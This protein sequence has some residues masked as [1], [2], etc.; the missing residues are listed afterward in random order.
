MNESSARAGKLLGTRDL[1]DTARYPIDAPDGSE[2]S[3]TVAFARAALAD[4]NCAVL[5]GF[6]KPDV[7]VA[8]RNEAAACAPQATYTRAWLNPYFSEAAAE[9]P[10]DHPLNRFSLRTHGMVR[11]D[12]FA[13]D[14]AIWQAFSNQDLCRFIARC[15]HQDELH[16]YGDP[17]GCVN[18]NVQEP[19]STFA[20]HFDHND[21]TVSMLLQAPESGRLFEYVPDTRT[22]EDPCYDA[23]QAVLDGRCEKVHVLDLR[24]G[25]LQ[26]FRVG[27]TLHR[28][29]AP[30]GE[31][32]P[33]HLSQAG[34]QR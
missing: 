28:V 33:L 7:L 5:P 27:N 20:W 11:G 13:R 23:V 34:P 31:A 1:F 2:Y 15:L 21:V 10:E 3:R 16:P 17:F 6:L 12:R 32:H 25:D 29:T 22:R 18:V 30:A 24:L 14:G 19:G 8:M 4:A 9:L 26:L